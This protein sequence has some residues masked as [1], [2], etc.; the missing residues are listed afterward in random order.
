MNQQNTE[1]KRE[2]SFRVTG[3]TP[4][5]WDPE[6]G[7]IVRTANYTTDE[8]YTTLPV[9]LKPY[10]SLLFVFKDQKPGDHIQRVSSVEK[11]FLLSEYSGTISFEPGYPASISPVKF[12]QLEWLTESKD[13]DIKYFAGTANYT[14]SFK[15]PTDKVPPS[16]SILLDIGDFETL[17][18][19]KLNGINLGRLW[20]PGTY[21]YIK[22][23]LKADNLLEVSVANIYRNR[24]IGDFIQY[25]KVKNLFTSSPITDFLNKDMPLR[26]S[27]LKGPVRI[28]GI[29][30]QILN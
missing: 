20:K 3:K 15:F 24:F 25:G 10:Q 23:M 29:S 13:P 19:V 30:N 2:M 22:G 4:E 11:E 6:Y 18:E 1:I 8:N 27:G 7:S 28:I 21:L 17:A 12:T 5:V 9:T 16:D 14:I 26:P